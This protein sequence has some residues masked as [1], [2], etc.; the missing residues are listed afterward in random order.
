MY[1]QTHS[2][3][4]VCAL[5]HTHCKGYS[6]NLPFTVAYNNLKWVKAFDKKKSRQ[7]AVKNNMRLLLFLTALALS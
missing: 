5:A 7:S 3:N 1:V 4:H 2:R 6:Y